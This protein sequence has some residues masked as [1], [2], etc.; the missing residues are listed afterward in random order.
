MGPC[1]P[2]HSHIA[3]IYGKISKSKEKQITSEAGWTRSNLLASD[4][5]TT[6][7]FGPTCI[8]LMKTLMPP[9]QGADRRM[10]HRCIC[11]SAPEQWRLDMRYLEPWRYL[12]VPSQNIH[13]GRSLSRRSLRGDGAIP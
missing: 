11:L 1:R 2:D 6:G 7:T 12:P 10:T 4:L 8:G 3:T 9:V 5:D 13:S